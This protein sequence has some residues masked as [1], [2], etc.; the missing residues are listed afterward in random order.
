M[1]IWREGVKKSQTNSKVIKSLK[2]SP[3][4]LNKGH[5]QVTVLP[6]AQVNKGTFHSFVGAQILWETLNSKSYAAPDMP[7][8]DLLPSS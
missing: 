6:G 2:T 7:A 5:Y 4:L 3:F 1:E 8:L